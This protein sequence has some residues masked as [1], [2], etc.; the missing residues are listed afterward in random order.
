MIAERIESLRTEASAHRHAAKYADS[1]QTRSA[2]LAAATRAE[3]AAKRLAAGA[4]RDDTKR[5]NAQLGAIHKGAKTLG[6][7]DDTYRALLRRVTAE[8][9]GAV[10]DSAADLAPWERE[11]VLDEYRRLGWKDSRPKGKWERKPKVAE[12]KEVLTGKIEA[13]LTTKRQ[14]EGT[15]YLSWKY[16]DGIARRVAKVDA[17]QFCDEANLRKV[18]AAL[19]IHVARL[20]KGAA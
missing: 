7:D 6:L 1:V 12:S 13:L 9:T 15:P 11:A 8:V 19:A 10:A 17:L 3:L 14:I 4:Q 2:D 18:V 16:A 20:K 5:R